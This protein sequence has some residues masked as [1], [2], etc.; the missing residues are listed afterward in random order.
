MDRPLGVS[1][2]NN[3]QAATGGQDRAIGRRYPLQRAAVG[4]DAGPRCLDHR[5]S[6]LRAQ[7]S[8]ASR[9]PMPSGF[10]AARPRRLSHRRGRG[11]IG[12]AARQ[13][14]ARQ[15]GHV[16]ARL[17][18][19]ADPDHAAVVP[20]D[21]VQLSRRCQYDPAYDAGSVK[22]RARSRCAR[23]T[24]LQRA[25]F[26]QGVSA[27]EIAAF[28]QAS[29]GVIA[30]NVKKLKAVATSAG[31]RPRQQRLV[32]LRLQQLAFAA[33]IAQ[34]SLLRLAHAHLPVSAGGESD[35]AATSGGDPRARSQSEERRAG[36]DGMSFDLFNL[37]PAVYRIRDCATRAVAAAADSRRRRLSYRRSKR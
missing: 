3:P 12:A 24:A 8:P 35:V 7:L 22:Q 14:D 17:R 9:R 32:C 28:I 15:S 36:G 34:P 19:S 13:S 27:D 31:R 2:V 23:T 30:V 10:R 18:Q 25:T 11:R 1:G 16:A 6:E 29:P 4:S 20:G 21:A 5:L 33:G 26:G 37:L